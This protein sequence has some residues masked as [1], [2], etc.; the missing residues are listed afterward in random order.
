[1]GRKKDQGSEEKSVI[2]AFAAENLSVRDISEL[3]KR[4]KSAVHQVIVASNNGKTK[5][6]PGPK[7]KITKTQDRAIVRAISKGVPTARE[8]RD[9]CNCDVT[10]RRIQQVLRNVP[11]SKHKKC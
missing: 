10:V 8:V 2:S 6:L 5:G 4:F 9:T 1:M 3:V 7:P 11:Y